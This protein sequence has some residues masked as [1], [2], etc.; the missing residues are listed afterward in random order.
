MKKLLFFFCITAFF[1]IQVMNG[2]SR[3]DSALSWMNDAFESAQSE[4][5]PQDAYY[6]GRAVAANILSVYRPYTGNPEL[7][8]YLNLICQAIVINSPNPVLFNGYYVLIL[9]SP[10]FNAF[11]TPGGHIFI[12]RGLVEAATSE[13]MLAAVIAHEVAHIIMEHGIKMIDE[14]RFAEDA[15]A[16][17]GRAANFSGN[18]DVLLLYRNSVAN[19]ADTMMK[20]GYSQTQEFEADRTAALLLAAS[21]YNPGAL[22]EMLRMLQRVQSSQRGGFNTTHPLPAE[23]IANVQQTINRYRVQDT[24]TYRARRFLN[25]VN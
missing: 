2:Q 3:V 19:L 13:D 9:D 5:T 10:E 18:A 25:K 8:R 6:L 4:T 14:M 24:S 7:T 1:S 12:T 21:G 15:T 11:A 16:I 17:A 22:V 23:R 20:N